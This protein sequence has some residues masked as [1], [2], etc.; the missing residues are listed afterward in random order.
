[1]PVTSRDVP[2]TLRAAIAELPAEEHRQVLGRWLGVGYSHLEE[3]DAI[4][5]SLGVSVRRARQLRNEAIDALGTGP[6]G[7][8][9][10]A[11]AAD[12]IPS[13]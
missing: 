12:S 13:S 3:L 7:E 5:V 10:R 8:E 6:Y 2:E 1:M 4:A 9:L 11:I